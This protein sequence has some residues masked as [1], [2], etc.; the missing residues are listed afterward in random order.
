VYRQH[1]LMPGNDLALVHRYLDL[2]AS[3]D[4]CHGPV[5]VLGADAVRKLISYKSGKPVLL[6]ES[7][8]VEPRHAGPFQLYGKDKA[9]VLLHDVLFAPFFA[10]AAGGGQIWHWD[11]YVAK[12]D[13]WRQYRRF[14]EFVKGVDPVREEFVPSFR[15]EGELRVYTL[16]GKRTTLVWLRDSRNDWRS[17]LERGEEPGL[18]TGARLPLKGKA[19][20]YDPWTG[21]WAGAEVS[22]LP[23]FRRSLCVKVQR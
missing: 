20:A 12:N 22:R 16:H 13:L 2:G 18:I 10:G 11:Q 6:A 17:E 4:V 19:R 7:G 5:D 8:A 21:E 1:S 23:D 15:E 9:G 14:S 3:L